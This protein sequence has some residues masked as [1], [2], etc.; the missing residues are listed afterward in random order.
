VIALRSGAGKTAAVNDDLAPGLYEELVSAALVGRLASVED[1]LVERIALRPAD[2]ADRIAQHLAREVVRAIGAVPEAERVATG[3]EVAR[4]L[5]VEIAE[6]LPRS[7]AATA[8]PTDPASVLAAIGE[9]DDAG[10]VATPGRG[11]AAQKQGLTQ[12]M[13]QMGGGGGDECQFGLA[14]PARVMHSMQ[15]EISPTL[16]AGEQCDAK[17]V[18]E[19]QRAHDLSVTRAL[20][21]VSEGD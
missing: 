12:R 15:A 18:A 14:E 2:A 9:H 7:G 10:S 19:P 4:R 6:R 11:R 21:A 8:T 1:A 13:A 17:L 16:R 3:I 20:E 5:I